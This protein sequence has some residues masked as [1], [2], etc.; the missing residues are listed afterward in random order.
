MTCR[1]FIHNELTKY[2]ILQ[3]K[4]VSGCTKQEWPTYKGLET[5][6]ETY[7]MTFSDFNDF[8]TKKRVILFI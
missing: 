5:P 2:P 7:F 3:S 8:G 6:S 4:K 1:V